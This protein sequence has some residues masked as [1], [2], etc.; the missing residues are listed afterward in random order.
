MGDPDRRPN[1]CLAP[2]ERPPFYATA[3]FPGDVG[4]FGGLLTDEHAR[5]LRDDGEPI[6]RLYAAGNI[7]ASVAGRGY[8][9]AGGSIGPACTFGYV[10]MSHIAERAVARPTARPLSPR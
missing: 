5:V 1:N 7:T 9:G 6:P 3:I 10:A 8:F 2:L 4:T